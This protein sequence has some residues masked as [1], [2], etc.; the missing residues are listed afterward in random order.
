MNLSQNSPSL[1]KL[2]IGNCKLS[3]DAL[4]GLIQNCKMLTMLNFTSMTKFTA[5]SIAACV[6][7][8]PLLRKVDLQQCKQ[9]T[10][11]VI[12]S[13]A[14]NCPLLEELVR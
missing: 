13:L 6:K 11:D 10:D 7:N 5:A 12:L 8:S 9:V 2:N 1:S 4:N 14:D 3:N